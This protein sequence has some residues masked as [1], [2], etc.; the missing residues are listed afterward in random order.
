MNTSTP[1]E[2]IAYLLDLIE[3]RQKH[4]KLPKFTFNK[5]RLYKFKRFIKDM[6][7]KYEEEK[8]TKNVWSPLEFSIDGGVYIKDREQF[9]Y[10][11]WTSLTIHASFDYFD[12]N[13]VS[14]TYILD[15]CGFEWRE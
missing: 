12:E 1:K 3:V 9:V 6:Y 4:K 2:E 15:S 5:S 11:L 14:R 13:N 10:T 7:K 8:S